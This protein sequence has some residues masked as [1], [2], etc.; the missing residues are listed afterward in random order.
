MR[1]WCASVCVCEYDFLL[2]IFIPIF[3]LRFIRSHSRPSAQASKC[4]GGCWM[5]VRGA[6]VCVRKM[7]VSRINKST[8]YKGPATEM[9]SVR[10]SRT[11]ANTC[12]RA[13]TIVLHTR[14]SYYSH[15]AAYLL[16]AACKINGWLTF[17]GR[18]RRLDYAM[19]VIRQEHLHLG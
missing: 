3:R 4:C 1:E 16:W 17:V 12:V 10:L 11:D 2:F 13:A 5:C 9:V 6:R 18:R 15:P 8:K 19:C 14:D 7:C